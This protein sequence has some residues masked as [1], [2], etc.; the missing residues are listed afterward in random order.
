MT[1]TY[2]TII[3]CGGEGERIGG[4]KPQRVLAGKTLLERALDQASEFG[5][6]TALA[7][8][9]G[10]DISNTALPCLVDEAHHMGPVAALKSAFSFAQ[11]H[12]ATHALLI[13]CD[14]PF[15]PADLATRLLAT[16]GNAGAAIPETGGQPHFMAGLWR[17]DVNAL[18]SYIAKGGRSLWRFSEQVGRVL[19]RWLPKDGEDPFTDIDDPAALE[20]AEKRLR[21][22]S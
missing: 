1:H 14:Q 8:R 12:G 11:I 7:A 6:P 13:G 9:Q 15:L 3:A 16:I 21:D 17:A 10:M 4:G 2:V 20:R 5:A 22:R 18:D 19:V